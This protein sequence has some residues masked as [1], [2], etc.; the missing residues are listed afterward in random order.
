MFT[1]KRS[2]SGKLIA[3]FG[4]LFYGRARFYSN[5][6]QQLITNQPTY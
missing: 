6:D 4:Q 3:R 2:C 5:Y 1:N